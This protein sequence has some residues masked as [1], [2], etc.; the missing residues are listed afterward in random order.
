M[1]NPEEARKRLRRFIEEQMSGNERV[2]SPDIA[3]LCAEKFADDKAM[4]TG[5][6]YPAVYEATMEYM[7]DT[8]NHIVVNETD[9]TI[10]SAE[11]VVRS[12]VFGKQSKFAYW[13]EWNGVHHVLFMKMKREDCF[14]AAGKRRQRERTENIRAT[15]LETVGN[16][17]TKGKK[18]EDVYT[19][20]DIER[21]EAEITER[22]Y[23]NND[24]RS[25]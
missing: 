16:K 3:R 6:L 21:I 18:V 11:G 7:R 13:R 23:G 22:L 5:L 12:S 20:E 8:H 24:R 25:A 10:C 9:G 17:L 14:A 19:P 2:S 1:V 4:L 15:L